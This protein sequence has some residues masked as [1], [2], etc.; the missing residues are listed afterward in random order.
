[1]ANGRTLVKN[2]II[3]TSDT[4]RIAFT[5][6]KKYVPDERLSTWSFIRYKSDPG[7]S[8]QFIIENVYND[9]RPRLLCQEA[10][11]YFWSTVASSNRVKDGYNEKLNVIWKIAE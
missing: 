4:Q 5:K 3:N 2:N 10:D 11:P 7:F 1:M 8:D 9:K 6:I